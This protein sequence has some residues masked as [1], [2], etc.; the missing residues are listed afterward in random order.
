MSANT[1]TSIQGGDRCAVSVI[2]HPCDGTIAPFWTINV[3]VDSGQ[4]RNSVRIFSEVD[5]G[6]LANVIV[7]KAVTP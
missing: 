3:D 2:Y 7:L 6:P 5:P 1:H 4:T